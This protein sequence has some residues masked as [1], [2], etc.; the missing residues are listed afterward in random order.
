[1]KD[2]MTE[3]KKWQ[4]TENSGCGLALYVWG[5]D[6]QLIYAHAGYDMPSAL[7]KDIEELRKGGDPIQNGWNG[8]D[9]ID[10][11]IV[12][13]VRETEDVYTDDGDIIPL[14]HEEYYDSDDSTRVI[15]DQDG[16]I[17]IA[18]MGYAGASVFA[19]AAEE[20]RR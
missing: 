17:L 8:N 16:P 5:T 9:L 2:Q 10:E 1:M 14:T 20:E 15:C 6:G 7:K 18:D 3:V 4:V 11:E 19:P 13:D 12:K